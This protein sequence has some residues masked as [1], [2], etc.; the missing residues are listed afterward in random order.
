MDAIGSMVIAGYIFYI[1]YV[2]FKQS[3]LNLI[4]AWENPTAVD[5]IKKILEENEDFKK[6]VKIC[7]IL[8]RPVGTTGAYAEVHLEIE[9]SM[10]LTDV[11]LLCIQIETAIKS[12]ISI[13]KRV[14]TI[15][16]CASPQNKNIEE[17]MIYN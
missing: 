9:G 16:H 7:S 11:E 5:K 1:A 15:P 6:T 12:G 2:S 3:S 14:T 13:I 10:L 8:L 17:R 4:D